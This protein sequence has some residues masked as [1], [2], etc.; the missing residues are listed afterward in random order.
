LFAEA[1]MHRDPIRPL[2]RLAVE[3]LESRALLSANGFPISSAFETGGFAGT[4][5]VSLLPSS[6]AVGNFG[7]Q[8]VNNLVGT[9][10][11]SN[12]V[13]PASNTAAPDATTGVGQM[14]ITNGVNTPGIGS[15]AMPTCGTGSMGGSGMVL[16]ADSQAAQ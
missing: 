3:E 5:P 2:T 12:R 9:A 10:S 4:L 14:T 13:V 1:I 15:F 16:H 11:A 8:A 6:V 7:P